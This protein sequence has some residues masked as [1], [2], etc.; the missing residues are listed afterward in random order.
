[1]GLPIKSGLLQLLLLLLLS[2]CVAQTSSTPIDGDT[3]KSD[4][5]SLA[6]SL[7]P[8]YLPVSVSPSSPCGQALK[9]MA[10]SLASNSSLWAYKI[11]DSWGKTLD[12][13]GMLNYHYFGNYDECVHTAAG[14]VTGKY[15]TVATYLLE[16]KRTTPRL[17]E[18]IPWRPGAPWVRDV[19]NRDTRIA[20]EGIKTDPL[21]YST[22][23]PSVCT[24]QELQ[25]SLTKL[26]LPQGVY[27]DVS[28]C[29]VLN[30]QVEFTTPDIGFMGFLMFLVVLVV[31][32]S[33]VDMWLVYTGNRRLPKGVLRYLL[34]F[35][36][37]TN[38]GKILRV[39]PSSTPGTISCL[40]AMRYNNI[41]ERIII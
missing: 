35:S 6:A 32:A 12:G 13:L 33:L 15:C 36:A 26:L 20:S 16:D 25:D 31:C 30:P 7:A 21:S 27:P 28:S 3:V 11:V 5:R 18:V 2:C 10:T 17:P 40:H 41:S 38:L 19:L 22:C 23:M 1:M 34:V 14:S 4:L 29:A 24:R 39:N 8:M 9:D 37:Y